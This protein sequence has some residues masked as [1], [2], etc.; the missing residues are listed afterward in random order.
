MI[1]A[2]ESE[3]DQRDDVAEDN[4]RMRK[5]FAGAAI[6]AIATA[7]AAVNIFVHAMTAAADLMNSLEL[8]FIARA[9]SGDFQIWTCTRG[10]SGKAGIPTSTSNASSLVSCYRPPMSP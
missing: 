7:L 3:G 4:G 8:G 10:S 2:E 9:S 6:T 1:K 5:I